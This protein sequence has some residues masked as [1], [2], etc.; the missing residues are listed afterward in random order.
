MNSWWF[1]DDFKDDFNDSWINNV[2]GPIDRTCWSVKYFIALLSLLLGYL[3]KQP[4]TKVW[5]K[6]QGQPFVFLPNIYE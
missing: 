2:S 5:D 4:Y 6:P 3:S 1:N